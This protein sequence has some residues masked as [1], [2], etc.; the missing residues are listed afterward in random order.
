SFTPIP[1]SDERF[2]RQYRCGP[3]PEF[4]LASPRSGIVHHLSGPDRHAHTLTLLRRSR[5][6]GSV[7]VRY[8]ANQLPCALRFYSPVDSYTCQTPWSVFQDGSIGEPTARRCR[9]TPPQLRQ[10]RL[11]G[12]NKSP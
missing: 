2:A 9:G 12:R 7:P 3:P 11:R 6:V 4:P 5:S 1:K 8:P 10:R